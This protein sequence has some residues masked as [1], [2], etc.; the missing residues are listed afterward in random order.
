MP[1]TTRLAQLIAQ[2]EGFG[3]PGVTPTI[4]HNP[5][6]LRHSPHSVHTPDAPNA[7]GT[8][9]NDDDGWADLERQLRIY[10]SEK[11]TLRAMVACYAP[12]TEND[13]SEYLEFVCDGLA[14][15]PETLV[16]QAL[17]IPAA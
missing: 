15:I 3:H 9:D 1:A 17:T 10:A 14:M 12:P 7:I 4:R 5:G 11:M 2:Q 6:D 8:I 16:S 13:T